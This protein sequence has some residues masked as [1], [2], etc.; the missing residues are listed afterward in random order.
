MNISDLE[1]IFKTAKEV[2]AE[3]IGVQIYT[4]GN[5]RPEIIINHKESF[6]NKLGYYK[7]AYTND[8]ILK[9]YNGISIKGIAFGNSFKEIE[10]ALINYHDECDLN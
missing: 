6:Y 1:L 8:L 5:L 2:N 7:K 3:Y 4:R 10:D 9:S